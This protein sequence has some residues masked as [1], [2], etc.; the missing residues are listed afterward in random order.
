MPNRAVK[1]YFEKAC[2]NGEYN[3][4]YDSIVRVL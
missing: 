1:Y 4:D 2:R 3:A